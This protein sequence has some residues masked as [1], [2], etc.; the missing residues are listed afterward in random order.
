MRSS[1]RGRNA[2]NH[3]LTSGP[4]I[5]PLPLDIKKSIAQIVRLF[6][7]TLTESGGSCLARAAIGHAVLECCGIASQLVAGSM[8]YRC[9]PHRY[10]DTLRFCLPDNRGGYFDGYLTGHVWNAVGDE[11]ADFSAGDWRS[12]AD[13]LYATATDDADLAL[14]PVEWHVSPPD[15]IWEPAS[16]LMSAWKP[17]GQPTIGDIWYGPWGTARL[18]DYHAYDPIVES[19]LS[20][21][22]SAVAKFHVQERLAEICHRSRSQP[23]HSDDAAHQSIRGFQRLC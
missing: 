21:I 4:E 16:S 18:P 7:L 14:G 12:E 10:R 3:I 8:L 22:R 17:S 13:D 9:G 1:K 23:H 11:I 5:A 20:T 2:P 6:E 15:F 19:A